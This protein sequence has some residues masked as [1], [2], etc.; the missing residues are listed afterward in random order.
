NRPVVLA[1]GA[2]LINPTTGVTVA[3]NAPDPKWVP[4]PAGGQLAQVGPN[5][6][7]YS[8]PPGGAA[9]APGANPGPMSSQQLLPAVIAQESGGVPRPGV[10]TQ[11]GTAQGVG[12][13]LPKTAE[14]TAR[15][16]GIPY[17]PVLAEGKTPEAIAYQTK[18]AQAY[19]EQGLQKYGGDPR[20]ALMFYHGGPDEKLWGPKTHAYA[21]QVLSRLQGGGPAPQPNIIN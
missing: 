12:Q 5:G 2:Q 6:V 11:Y 16:L 21:D 3:T 13:M 19:L 7:T 17:E 4:I 20:K 1:D 9:S 18:L 15:A 14:G 8:T 10:P